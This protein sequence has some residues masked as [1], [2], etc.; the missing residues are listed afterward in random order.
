MYVVKYI[1]YLFSILISIFVF[2]FALYVY[3]PIVSHILLYLIHIAYLLLTQYY[4]IKYSINASACSLNI[5]INMERKER[6]RYSLFKIIK[7][8]LFT[9]I[10]IIILILISMIFLNR[11]IDIVIN[12]ILILIAM[13]T[14]YTSIICLINTLLKNNYLTIIIVVV[15]AAS[16]LLINNPYV[17]PLI[18]FPNLL[19][20]PLLFSISISIVLIVFTALWWSKIWI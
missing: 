10:Y 5:F 9:N 16:G 11:S 15:I 19:I 17:F 6:F 4:L 14:L 8:V 7:I 18:V 1:E 13:N 20:T 12:T 2:T 3:F